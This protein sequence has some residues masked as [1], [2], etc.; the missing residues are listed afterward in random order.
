M[1]FELL[2]QVTSAAGPDALQ[3]FPTAKK[4]KTFQIVVEIDPKL[5]GTALATALA[6][7]LVCK[8][9]IDVSNDGKNWINLYPEKTV[10]KGA[11]AAVAV[12]SWD[13][14]LAQMW[15]NH[16]VTATQVDAGACVSVFMGIEK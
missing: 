7:S 15:A 1:M 4:D 16:K 5:T 11:A 6:A 14:A 10:T 13:P 2:S 3:A 8:V 12:D 9:K